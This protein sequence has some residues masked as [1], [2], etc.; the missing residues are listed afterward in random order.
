MAL[1]AGRAGSRPL[2]RLAERSDA[3]ADDGRDRR[4]AFRAVRGRWPTVEALAAAADEEILS[5]W[6]G[7]GYYARAR[8]LIACA[9]EVASA[10]RISHDRRGIEALP[11][12]G[13]YTAAA[14]AAIAFG[15]KAPAVDT[16]VE[17]VVARLLWTCRAASERDRGAICWR[18]MEV[19]RPGDVV[20]ALMDLGATICRPEAATMRRLPAA[21]RVRCAFASG[22]PE[23]F[24]V[25]RPR[26]V[27]PASLWHRLVDRARRACL[28]RSA[29]RQADCSAGWPRFPGAS[30]A[31]RAGA[32]DTPLRT[33][34]HVFTHFTL[35]LHLIA[36]R[37]RTRRARAGGSQLT[38]SAKPGFRHFTQRPPV[39][40]LRATPTCRPETFFSGPGLDRADPLRPIAG[41]LGELA[42]SDAHASWC[43]ST[44]FL[45]WRRRRGSSG[46]RSSRPSCSS[47]ST[48]SEP[49][50]SAIRRTAEAREQPSRSW[51]N[52]I[53]RGRSD[54]RRRAQPCADGTRAIASARIAVI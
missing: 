17:R 31:K 52:L 27:A 3:P 54:L 53:G 43:G 51:R 11:G 7:L 2:S 30:G 47:A 49:R 36:K 12:I 13:A 34:R 29:A 15:E 14:I 33:V 22:N 8:N 32:R 25:P 35:D 1:A 41:R 4:A 50:F 18:L 9:R 19:H 42:A 10:R 6:A 5:E 16:N 45:Q 37:A 46:R 28:A 44:D 23:S 39:W 40:L 38:G 21:R 48:A 26:K 20:Q 24:P